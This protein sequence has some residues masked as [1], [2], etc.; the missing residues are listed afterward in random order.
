MDRGVWWATLAKCLAQLSACM[1]VHTHTHTH[2]HT[3]TQ[4]YTE[5]SKLQEFRLSQR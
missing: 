3:H 1:R 5:G 2:A 4:L